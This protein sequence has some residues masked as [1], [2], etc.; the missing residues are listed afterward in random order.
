MPKNEIYTACLILIGNELLSGRTQDK[1]LAVI[2]KGLN[3]MGIR[4]MAAHVIP[5]VR[6]TIIQ[7]I[8]TVRAEYDYVFTTGGIGPTHDDITTECVAKAFGVE[9]YVDSETAQLL[10]ARVESRGEEMNDARLRMAT[11]PVGAELLKNEI[12]VAPGYKLENVFVMAGVPKIMQMMFEEAKSHLKGGETVKS[13]GIA[14]DLGEG[15]IADPL[16]NLQDRYPMLDIGSYPQ[17]RE[18]VGFRVSL[19]LRGIDEEILDQAHAELM[20]I[21]ADLGGKP[22]EED[23]EKSQGSAEPDI[24]G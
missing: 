2:A 14:I 1:N 8:N 20:A 22:I 18:N 10:R 5:D 23:P 3:D 17:M 24:N 12:S 21:L 19:V 16:A 13:R 11:F 15:T 7:T 4:M 9:T 6:E